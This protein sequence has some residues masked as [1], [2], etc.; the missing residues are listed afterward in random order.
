MIDSIFVAMSGLSGH[1]K[2]LKVISNNVANMNTAGFKGSQT[3]FTDV[4]LSQGGDPAVGQNLT[5]GGGMEMLRSSVN[6]T[7]GELRETGRE[8]DMALDGAGFFVVRNSQGEILYSKNGRFE[9]NDAGHLV[10]MD[11]GFEVMGLDGGGALKPI[12]LDRLGVSENKPTTSVVLKGN[13][14][15]TATA[16]TAGNRTINGIKVYDALGTERTLNILLKVA[17]TTNPTDNTTTPISGTWDVTISEGTT[18]LATGQYK[19]TS[20]GPNPLNDRITVIMTAAG[21]ARTAVT[22]S[23]NSMVTGLSRGNDAT[24][25]GLDTADGNPSGTLSKTTFDALGNLVITYTNTKTAKGGQLA[26]AEFVTPEVLTQASGTL[27]RQ[28]EGEPVRYVAAGNQTKLKSSTLELANVDL[29]D[30][31]STMILVQRGFQASSQVLSTASEMIQSL[32][33]L[34]GRR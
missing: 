34:K 28:T 17:T 31:F 21:G 29:T 4:F 12:T 25:L 18:T 2:G 10:M 23:L 1:Q 19:V 13:L 26:V 22:V 15:S 24:E 7:A 9:F 11:T 16:D 3:Q 27:F 32:Y 33:D 30:Q 6:F 8:M 14:S 5:P 20:T